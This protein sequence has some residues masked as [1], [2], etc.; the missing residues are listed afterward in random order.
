MDITVHQK[1]KGYLAGLEKL[2]VRIINI[3][4]KAS[5]IDAFFIN[6]YFY[7]TMRNI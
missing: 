4:K 7:I 1:R 5:F 3:K 6:I 2:K